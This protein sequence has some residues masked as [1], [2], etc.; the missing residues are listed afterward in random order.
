MKAFKFALLFSF[1]WFLLA[2]GAS[3][4]EVRQYPKAIPDSDF[5]STD[6]AGFAHGRVSFFT[7][8]GKYRADF[9]VTNDSGK[10]MDFTGAKYYAIGSGGAEYDLTFKEVAYNSGSLNRNI[11]I[12]G[13]MITIY[14]N[15]RVAPDK[16]EIKEINIILKDG[17]N[18]RFIPE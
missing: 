2:C 15:S 14:C 10:P 16:K 5:R 8:G 1:L 11:I 9:Q 3:P 4:D 18:L 12:A 6:S 13:D 7:I 17:R